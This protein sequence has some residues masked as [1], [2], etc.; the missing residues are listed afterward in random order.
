MPVAQPVS[1]NA[2]CCP[3]DEPVSGGG[4]AVWLMEWWHPGR[5]LEP[6]VSWVPPAAA[7]PS[8]SHSCR[9]SRSRCGAGPQVCV[10][11]LRSTPCPHPTRRPQSPWYSPV[12][13]PPPASRWRCTASRWSEGSCWAP[14][15]SRPGPRSACTDT[16][17][18]C[19][20]AASPAGSPGQKSGFTRGTW[21]WYRELWHTRAMRWGH[22][23]ARRP[24]CCHSKG[25]KQETE[26]AGGEEEGLGEPAGKPR[27]PRPTLRPTQGWLPHHPPHL[28]PRTTLFRT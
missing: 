3:H 21:T 23:L 12:P 8:T 7:V 19:T 6:R 24:L 17:Y 15:S 27:E 26:E 14:R 2:G 11:S 5:R 25:E 10:W 20:G 9:M 1:R 18:R 16:A 4:Q 28:P 22:G 13:A